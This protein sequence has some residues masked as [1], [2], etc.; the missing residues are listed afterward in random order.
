[1]R[2]PDGEGLEEGSVVGVE[3][4]LEDGDGEDVEEGLE[5]T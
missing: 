5:T 4:G 3:E 2:K 1:M